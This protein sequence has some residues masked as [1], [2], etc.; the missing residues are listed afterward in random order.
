MEFENQV[1]IKKYCKDFCDQDFLIYNDPC[2]Q[3]YFEDDV[4]VV[5]FN[6]N[7]QVKTT[8]ILEVT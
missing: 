8:P 2:Q 5:L 3:L 7:F 1:K 4:L 6:H